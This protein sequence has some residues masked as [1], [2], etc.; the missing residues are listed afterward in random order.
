MKVK[1]EKFG[2]F[3]SQNTPVTNTTAI[4]CTLYILGELIM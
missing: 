4:H 3:K 1:Y 2:L